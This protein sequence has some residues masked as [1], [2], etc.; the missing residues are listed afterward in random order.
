MHFFVGLLNLAAKAKT[1]PL[2]AWH[3]AEAV[4][5]AAEDSLPGGDLYDGSRG[6][7][8]AAQFM[9]SSSMPPPALLLPAS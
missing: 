5:V 8:L 3:A 9:S 2:A 6:P 7:D 1:N 4:R